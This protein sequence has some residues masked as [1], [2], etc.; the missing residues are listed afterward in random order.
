M[1][2]VG[3]TE[4]LDYQTY[5]ETRDGFRAA[6]LAE[7]AR[8]RIHV[9]GCLTFLFENP[10]TVRYQIQ[11]M[12]RVERIVRERDILHEIDTHNALLGA[13]G[14][15]GCSLLVE[16]DDPD[17]RSVRLTEW[18]RLPQHLY[19]RLADGTL[20]RPRFDEAQRGRGRLSSVQYLVFPV[21]G[22]VP[23]AIGSD[24]P[25]FTAETKLTDDQRAALGED[26][27]CSHADSG[28]RNA[29]VRSQDPAQ[30]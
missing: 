4:I 16:I 30:A 10:L 17:L 15:I 2:G 24:L 27:N 20:V 6:V 11:E 21:A 29:G 28:M 25:S 18:F 12:V 8:R 14:E 5:E 1:K 26:L 23:V 3:R 7:K 22:Q 19:S 13:E 9:G